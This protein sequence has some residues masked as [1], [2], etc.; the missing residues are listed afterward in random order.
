MK[1]K[2]KEPFAGGG[3]ESK[4]LQIHH[5][6]SQCYTYK[7]DVVVRRNDM[8]WH[9]QRDW[10]PLCRAVPASCLRADNMKLKLREYFVGGGKESKGL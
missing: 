1:V 9:W 6:M 3:K 8:A 2:L 10:P 4:G 5:N 7:T